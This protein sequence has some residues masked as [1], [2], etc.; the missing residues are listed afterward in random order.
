MTKFKKKIISEI[1]R[2]WPHVKKLFNKKNIKLKDF[3]F[4]TSLKDA[5][6]DADFIQ[7]VHLKIINVKIKLMNEKIYK[8]YHSKIFQIYREF[9]KYILNVKILLE[10]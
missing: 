6:I 10:L 8:I 2:T 9:Q 3:T 1:K 7:D 5:I 4:T